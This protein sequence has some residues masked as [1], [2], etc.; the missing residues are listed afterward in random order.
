[1][2]GYVSPRYILEPT[3]NRK[4]TALGMNV[5]QATKTVTRHYAV[6]K[7]LQNIDATPCNTSNGVALLAA[8]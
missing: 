5:M 3:Q 6:H 8:L 2:G 4:T 1:M 7:G